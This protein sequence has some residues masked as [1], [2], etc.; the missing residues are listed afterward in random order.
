MAQH[1][2]YK[3]ELKLW[4]QH[5]TEKNGE[6]KFNYYSVT[7]DVREVVSEA[8]NLGLSLLESNLGKRSL[9]QVGI[10][11]ME[12]FMREGVPH[13]FPAETVVTTETMTEEVTWYLGKLR[14]G[15][16]NIILTNHIEGEGAMDRHDWAKFEPRKSIRNYDPHRAATM[17][18][19]KFVRDSLWKATW[20][21]MIGKSPHSL[22][23]C[24][25]RCLILFPQRCS[26][27][28]HSSARARPGTKYSKFRCS[29]WVS[30]WPMSSS[31]HLS[32]S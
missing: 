20:T 25:R 1:H 11:L 28:S 24:S 18:L 6:G 14:E 8:V 19:S 9:V 29:P 27:R 30:P 17:G 31:T 4:D 22:I 12:H 15:F 21:D 32:G 13:M 16:M 3:S 10:S 2:Y 7:E 5:D 23:N 26:E